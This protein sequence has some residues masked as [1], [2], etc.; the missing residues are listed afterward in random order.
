MTAAAAILLLAA[1]HVH[2]AEARI[3]ARTVEHQA[4]RWRNPPLLVVALMSHEVR[5]FD[6]NAV[7]SR[8]ERGRLQ[9]LRDDT[10]TTKGFAHL[11]DEALAR[12]PINQF[13]GQRRLAWARSKCGPNPLLYLSH[14][15]GAGCR[16]TNYSKAIMEVVASLSTEVAER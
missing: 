1:G 6:K 11:S 4:T 2:A 14:Y 3:L 15:N 8:G 5:T 12:D 16:V 10:L 7:G 9:V 13:I